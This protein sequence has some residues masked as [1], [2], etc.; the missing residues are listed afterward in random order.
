ML[1]SIKI[2]IAS[3]A[4]A[5]STLAILCDNDC[6][7]NRSNHENQKE[8]YNQYEA[9]VLTVFA[10]VSKIIIA[11]RAALEFPKV[12]ELCTMNLAKEF[13]TATYASR[14]TARVTPVAPAIGYIRAKLLFALAKL[15]HQGILRWIWTEM[16]LEAG[17]DGR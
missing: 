13:F 11:V 15:L 8:N 6:H 2:S 7:R 3:P 16:V 1:S 12:I 10:G 17:R 5:S 9:A 14:Y 4:P